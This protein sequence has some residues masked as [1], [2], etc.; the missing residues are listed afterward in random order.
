MFVALLPCYNVEKNVEAVINE[1]KKTFKTIVAVDD[2]SM[3]NTGKI[4]KRLNIHALSYSLNKGKGTAI[5]TG[6]NYIKKHF[7][8]CEGVLLIDSDGQHDPREAHLFIEK[9]KETKADLIVGMRS[10]DKTMP[11]I[12]RMTNKVTAILLTAK[13]GKQMHDPLNGYKFLSKAF[14]ETFKIKSSRYEI[15]FEILKHA[16]KN[17][18]SIEWVPIKTIYPEEQGH[19]KSLPLK[20]VWTQIKYFWKL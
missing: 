16:L 3:D 14:V 2:G 6:L 10:F 13:C 15:D 11:W 7:K 12:R 17:S 20:D 1:L 8:D 19:F 5:N 9:F 18:L 4:L